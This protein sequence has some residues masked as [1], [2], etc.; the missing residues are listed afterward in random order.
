ME[1]IKKEKS[2]GA[3]YAA[4][5]LLRSPSAVQTAS[6][7]I[8]NEMLAGVGERP[9]ETATVEV[10]YH[11]TLTDGTVFDSSK[12]RGETIKFPLNGVIKGWQE[13]VQVQTPS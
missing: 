5:F 6:G 4:S 9:S 13:G 11:G 10:H 1:G 8:F 3:D 7:L 12:D 2:A